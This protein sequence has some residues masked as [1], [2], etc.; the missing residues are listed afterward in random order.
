MD[1]KVIESVQQRTDK[2]IIARAAK[3]E[4]MEAAV[5]AVAQ[6]EV[7]KMIVADM[8]TAVAMKEAAAAQVEHAWQQKKAAA[9]QVEHAWQQKKEQE[10]QARHRKEE[11]TPKTR[12]KYK[13]STIEWRT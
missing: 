6:R 8:L 13:H 7:I 5:A 9:A 4:E 10:E 12:G 2:V 1:C 3:V 11:Q